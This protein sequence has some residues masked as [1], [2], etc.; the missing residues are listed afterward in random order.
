M[1]LLITILAFFFF[2][3]VSAQSETTIQ[4]KNEIPVLDSTVGDYE[5]MIFID[6][7]L[8]YQNTTFVLPVRIELYKKKQKIKNEVSF[9]LIV[10]GGVIRN[11]SGKFR[12]STL[13]GNQISFRFSNFSID[14]EGLPFEYFKFT[15]PLLNQ[16]AT[17]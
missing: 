3:A 8:F 2:G 6:D 17:N 12:I 7:S 15:Y 14:N 4:I 13:S 10:S 9:S 16:Q 11:V 5:I 1:K